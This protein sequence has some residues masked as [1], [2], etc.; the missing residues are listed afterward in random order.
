MVQ[1][2]LTLTLK[3]PNQVD[4]ILTSLR[5]AHPSRKSLHGHAYTRTGHRR[6]KMQSSTITTM[7]VSSRNSA[8]PH[9][10][11]GLDL[12]AAGRVRVTLELQLPRYL[13]QEAVTTSPARFICSADLLSFPGR[14]GRGGN[15][16]IFH[17]LLP[18][19]FFSSLLP[20]QL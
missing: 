19:L 9:D 6:Q 15:C 8:S 3:R 11:T 14:S 16:A 10:K 20:L 2:L 5:S 13:K 1:C 4:L 18:P 7:A 17:S 12:L